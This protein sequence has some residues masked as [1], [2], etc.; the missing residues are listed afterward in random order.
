MLQNDPDNMLALKR[1]RKF[2]K[3][4]HKSSIIILKID[5]YVH[6]TKQFHSIFVYVKQE[7]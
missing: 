6:S 4:F 2:Y 3:I 5:Q 1:P 7:D